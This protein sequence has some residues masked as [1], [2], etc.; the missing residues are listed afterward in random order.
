M[1]DAPA[2]KGAVALQHL[3]AVLVPLLAVAAAQPALAQSSGLASDI[4]LP[5]P[6]S[7][8]T[9]RLDFGPR[10]YLIGARMALHEGRTAAARNALECA[11]TRLLNAGSASAR[12]QLLRVIVQA[13]HALGAN[14]AQ[15]AAAL[16]DSV[17]AVRVADS[18]FAPPGAP[19]A[20]EL[21][22]AYPPRSVGSSWDEEA[23]RQ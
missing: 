9:P 11:E 23:R 3:G 5:D 2:M 1:D 4:A 17:L 19:P 10:H 12:P 22:L 6:G 7:V 20:E 13:R 8:L 14:D 15:G 21:E 16:L 18:A